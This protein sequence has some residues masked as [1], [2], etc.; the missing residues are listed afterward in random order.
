[1]VKTSWGMMRIKDVRGRT[2]L[3]VKSKLPRNGWRT[4][5]TVAT[6][7]VAWCTSSGGR[8]VSL[9]AWAV[10]YS[11]IMGSIKWLHCPYWA[12]RR[13]IVPWALRITPHWVLP[14]PPFGSIW[15]PFP[16]WYRAT[17]D[18]SEFVVSFHPILMQIP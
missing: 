15:P 17:D 2:K 9:A 11:G 5:K 18:W 8:F 16:F 14:I 13:Q 3:A 1:L 10:G 12:C 6:Q 7:G 4:M